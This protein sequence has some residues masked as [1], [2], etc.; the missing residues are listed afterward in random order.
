MTERKPFQDIDKDYPLIQF[1]IKRYEYDEFDKFAE[2]SHT[3]VNEFL[4]FLIR[5]IINPQSS[6]SEGGEKYFK[7]L[8]KILLTGFD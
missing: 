5:G 4:Q 1:R 6:G 8:K 2:R 3:N 7:A